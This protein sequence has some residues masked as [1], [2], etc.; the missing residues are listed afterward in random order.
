[1]NPST[2]PTSD[3]PV[4]ERLRFVLVETSRAG[5]I[6][7]AARAIKTM[8]FSE[9]VLVCPREPDALHHAEAIAFASGATDVL[10]KA[11]IV[12]SLDEALAGC[13][14]TV[15]LS[16]RLREFSPPLRSPRSLAQQLHSD[17]SLRCALVFGSERFGL[18]NEQVEKCNALVSIPVSADYA[19]L[20]L[21]QAV[22]IL[23]Y[24]C[25]VA[26]MGEQRE[27]MG[28]GFQGEAASAEQIEGLFAHLEQALIEIE[29]LNPAHPK[30]LMPRLRRLFSRTGLETEEVNILRGI[31]TQI[32]ERRKRLK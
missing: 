1:M 3:V 21:A 24:E 4:F 30:K 16:A 22:Q 8:G 26:A 32:V 20:N 15:A 14:L 23:A 2:R 19:S 13:N 6:G 29:F 5:N 17:T 7:A 12:E 31:A 9:L 25:R 10:S 28:I 27:V 11:R 18:S